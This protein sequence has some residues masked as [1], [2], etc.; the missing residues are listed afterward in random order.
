[1]FSKMSEKEK[2]AQIKKVSKVWQA[3]DVSRPTPSSALSHS[4]ESG[5]VVA[6]IWK[7]MQHY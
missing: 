3:V 6:A 1:M 4:D 2:T 7:I 5:P